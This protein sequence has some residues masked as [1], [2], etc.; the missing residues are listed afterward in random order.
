MVIGETQILGQVRDAFLASQQLKATGAYFNTLFKQAVTLAK[1]A[2]S[3]TG[4]SNNP[5]S[6]SYAAVELGKRIFG[7]Y[8]N[9]TVMIIGAG[10]MSELTVKHLY[11]NGANKVIVVNR[12]FERALELAEKFNGYLVRWMKCRSILSEVDIIISSTGAPGYVL[13]RMKSSPMCKREN[14]VRSS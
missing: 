14:H 7:T 2:H 10:K 1:K 13:R 11:A 3:E 8:M 5:V 12:T 4:I 6:I 9:K